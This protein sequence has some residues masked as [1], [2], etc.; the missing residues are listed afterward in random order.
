MDNLRNLTLTV[1]PALIRRL[2]NGFTGNNLGYVSVIFRAECAGVGC[3]GLVMVDC[4]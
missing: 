2:V 3:I 1:L 4:I